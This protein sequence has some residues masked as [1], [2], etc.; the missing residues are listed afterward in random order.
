MAKRRIG[1]VGITPA[2]ALGVAFF[3]HLTGGLSRLD[4]NGELSRARRIVEW[5]RV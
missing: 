4:R 3:Y 5:G 1:T 2:G